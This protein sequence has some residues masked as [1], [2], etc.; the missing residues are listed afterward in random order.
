MDYLLSKKGRNTTLVEKRAHP[1]IP[2]TIAARFFYCNMFYTAT[3]TNLSEGG[4][5]IH[6]RMKLPLN[7]ALVIIMR[8]HKLTMNINA[9]VKR[10]SLQKGL[11]RGIGVELVRPSNQYLDY[12]CGF[13]GSD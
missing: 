2:S 4:M 10:T 11:L 8:E 3:I 6:T 1:R 13:K 9:R 12:V 7:S 5:F